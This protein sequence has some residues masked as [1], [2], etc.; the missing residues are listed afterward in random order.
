MESVEAHLSTLRALQQV[1]QS[2]QSRLS[3]LRERLEREFSVPACP[4]TIELASGCIGSVRFAPGTKASMSGSELNSHLNRALRAAWLANLKGGLARSA[5]G[6]TPRD[7]PGSGVGASGRTSD[8][9]GV[10]TLEWVKGQAMSITAR[11]NWLEQR[12][13]ADIERVIV[14]VRP[15][16]DATVG[17]N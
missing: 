13:E 11:E 1:A 15:P 7:F 16:A 3:D 8:P 12:S 5:Q 9:A 2:E 14:S 4:I 10:V 6:L 17:E